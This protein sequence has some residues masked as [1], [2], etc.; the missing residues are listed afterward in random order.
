MIRERNKKKLVRF[1]S[2]VITPKGVQVLNKSVVINSIVEVGKGSFADLKVSQ[3]LN[4]RNTNNS[5]VCMVINVSSHV[6]LTGVYYVHLHYCRRLL[7]N[8]NKSRAKVQ[9]SVVDK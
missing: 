5:S 1:L 8:D 3:K 6:K 2:K 4:N 9:Q 7:F